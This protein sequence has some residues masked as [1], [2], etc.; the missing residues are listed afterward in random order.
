MVSNICVCSP[1]FGEDS[2]FDLYFSD[3]LVQPPTRYINRSRICF[4]SPVMWSSGCRKQLNLHTG[5]WKK[6][7]TRNR[8]IVS[9]KLPTINFKNI[10]GWFQVQKSTNCIYIYIYIFIYLYIYI[11][12]DW[13]HEACSLNLPRTFTEETLFWV[14]VCYVCLLLCDETRGLCKVKRRRQGIL[15]AGVNGG[16]GFFT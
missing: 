9:Q 4:P 13:R 1:L 10:G 7:W 16:R 15:D 14:S 5:L 12:T 3:G 8:Q 6:M 2:H 11:F